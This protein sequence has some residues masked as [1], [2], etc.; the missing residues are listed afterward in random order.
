MGFLLSGLQSRNDVETQSYQNHV[1]LG[2]CFANTS[3]QDMVDLSIIYEDKWLIAVNKPSGLLSVPGR[4]LHNQD[5]VLSRLNN[6][7]PTAENFTAV[8]RLDMDTSGILLLAKDLETYRQ[9]SKQFQERHVYKVYEAVLAGVITTEEGIIE[10]PLWGNPD[11]RPYQEINQQY[12]KTS[13]TKFKLVKIENKGTRVEFIPLT[14]RTHQLRVHAADPQGLGI[15]IL[16]DRLYG[17]NAE[18]DRLHL[19]ARELYFNHP[20]IKQK[21]HLN[22]ETPF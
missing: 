16:G 10:L 11:N 4:Y 9:I 21:I 20:Q 18:V 12:G 19:H 7:L 1:S 14:G 8:H 17:C 15:S 5:S 13:L 3:P 2:E 6:L 22:V